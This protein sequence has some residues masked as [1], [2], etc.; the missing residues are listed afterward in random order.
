MTLGGEKTGGNLCREF[1]A[2]LFSE[3]CRLGQRPRHLGFEKPRTIGFQHDG[4]KSD[5]A[6]LD[7][8][9]C[10]DRRLAGAIENPQKGALRRKRNARRRIEN[11]REEGLNGT[12]ACPGGDGNRALTRRAG[13]PRGRAR[14]AGLLEARP[15]QTA[16]SQNRA[17]SAS[18]QA[19]RKPC[20]R[21]APKPGPDY[22]T[23]RCK[24]KPKH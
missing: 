3:Q 9:I 1:S 8:R 19:S 11:R 18:E 20:T 15:C 6:R 24:L 13:L 16:A 23:Y 7:A 12:V 10:A 4:V 2:R 14:R 22:P 21:G 17:T 5:V